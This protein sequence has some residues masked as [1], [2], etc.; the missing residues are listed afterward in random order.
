MR[1]ADHGDTSEGGPEPA[2]SGGGEDPHRSRQGKTGGTGREQEVTERPV[3][4]PELRP[5]Q[6]DRMVSVLGPHRRIVQPKLYGIENLPA[7]GSLL[8]ANH[9]STASWTRRS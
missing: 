2:A 6:M 3:E 5:E 8:A 1:G 4:I 7:D 9:T